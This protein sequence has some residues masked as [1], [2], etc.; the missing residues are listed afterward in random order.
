MLPPPPPRKSRVW[1]IVLAV[2]GALVLCGVFGNAVN[3]QST[4]GSSTANNS[5]TTQ[6]TDTPVPTTWT[7]IETFTGNGDK[8]TGTFSVPDDW[9]I[10]WSCQGLTDGTDVDGLLYISVYNSDG[11]PLD[12][13]AVGATCKYGK[14]TTDNTEEHQGGQVYLDINTGLSWEIEVQVLQ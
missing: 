10:I 4:T 12:L 9:R 5:A 11:S 7:T 6:A 13:S 14:M 8:K 3:S 1:L 2:V